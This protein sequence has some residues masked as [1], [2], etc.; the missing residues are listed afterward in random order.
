M[1]KRK[2]RLPKDRQRLKLWWILIRE[3]EEALSWINEI[4]RKIDT[5]EIYYPQ[6][7]LRTLY[8]VNNN[9]TKS[10]FGILTL[11]II[12]FL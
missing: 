11:N 10:H 1:K 8:K 5:L 12:L 7:R 2:D 6:Q 3:R 9:S 4:R